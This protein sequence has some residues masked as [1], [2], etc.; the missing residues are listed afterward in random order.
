M[1][2]DVIIIGAGQAGLSMG[3]YL[4]QTN[5]SFL[6]LDKANEIGETWKD[7]YDS[8]TLFTPRAYSS[9]P[10][11]KMDGNQNEYPTK[12][13]VAIYLEQYVNT[14]SL[15][16]QC[17]TTVERVSKTDNGFN[18]ITGN[19]EFK[20]RKVVI[21]TGPFQNPYIPEFS[22]EL[23][24]N[25]YQ[26]HSS[27]Y[28]NPTELNEGSV[29]VVGGGNSGAQIVVEVS[30]KRKTYFSVS[31]KMKFLP[32]DIGGKSIFW[33]FD[34]LGIYRANVHSL[35]GK[36][37]KRQH[38]PIFGFELKSQLKRGKITLKPRTKSI[39]N[40]IFV[41]DDES[42]VKVS[43]VIWAT[44]FKSDYSWI[45]IPY[46]INENGL[47]NHER[48]ITQIDG[49][50]FLGLAWQSSR[51]SAL[52]QGVGADAEYLFQDIVK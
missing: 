15:P 49:L 2:Y 27:Q 42:K 48:G 17:K 11:L 4:K 12:D 36:F 23:S 41:F 39:V 20:A 32:Q 8:L 7:R 46:L 43:N 19:G 45:D 13:E 3:H 21:A 22:K 14:F 1:K 33:Y 24:N 28:K 38:D 29:L 10:G 47:P 37:L 18:V 52:I 9:L 40:D 26:V 31:H 35:I 6:I 25:V 16:I 50:Y 34:K 30:K 5:L 44:G 51:G